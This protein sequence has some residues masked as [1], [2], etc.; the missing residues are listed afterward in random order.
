MDSVATQMEGIDSRMKSEIQAR[1]EVQ[2]GMNRIQ[3]QLDH[4]ARTLTY[5]SQ[6]I[7][8]PTITAAPSAPNINAGV[9]ASQNIAGPGNFIPQSNPQTL[10]PAYIPAMQFPANPQFNPHVQ[11]TWLMKEFQS[12]QEKYAVSERN[13]NDIYDDVERIKSD[14]NNRD[15]YDRRNNAITHGLKDVPIM[16]VRPKLEDQKKFTAYVVN[17]LNELFPDIEGGDLCS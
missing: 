11:L 5:P 3:S 13:I 1:Q 2:G 8:S 9:A 12:L 16:P 4:L 7:S 17:K 10:P 14:L 15:Q 6:S